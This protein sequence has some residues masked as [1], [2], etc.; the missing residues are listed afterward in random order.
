M[1]R[2]VPLGTALLAVAGCSWLPDRTLVYQEA[3]TAPRM[4]VPAGTWF[5][6]FDDLYPIEHADQRL[7]VKDSH[8][9]RFDAPQPPRVVAM[10]DPGTDDSTV[11]PPAQPRALLGRDGNGYPIIMLN[12][13]F[14]WA[15][16][17]VGDA[18]AKTPLK[19]D[20]RDREQGVFFVRVPSDLG[21]AVK[22]VQLKLSQTVNGTQVAV[23]NQTGTS[24]VEQDAGRIILE[25]LHSAL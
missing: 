2:L 22:Q 25:R 12:S 24:L 21:V 19:V 14:V 5:S 15:W 1:I 20:D 23:L 3:E 7:Q 16:Q 6:G 17:Y 4:E 13:P 9:G 18:L 8:R 11:P 10:A